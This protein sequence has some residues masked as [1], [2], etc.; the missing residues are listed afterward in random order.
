MAAPVSTP[1]SPAFLQQMMVVL[2][3][4]AAI[5]AT[6]ILLMLAMIGATVLAFMA[7]QNPEW[8]RL[9]ANAIYDILVIAPLTYLYLQK[10]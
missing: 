9:V 1:S 2:T 3:A 10:G 8:P 4:L 5:A 6:R 7:T